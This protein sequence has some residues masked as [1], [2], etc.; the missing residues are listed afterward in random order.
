MLFLIFRAETTDHIHS[1]IIEASGSKNL[2]INSQLISFSMGTMIH[3]MQ[4]HQN[5]QHLVDLKNRN[6]NKI[7]LIRAIP[8]SRSRLSVPISVHFKHKI[9]HATDDAYSIC[10]LWDNS[11]HKW[12]T[13]DCTLLMSNRSHSTCACQKLATYALLVDPAYLPGHDKDAETD[14]YSATLIMIIVASS[15][16]V[17]LSILIIAIVIVYCRN[18]KVIIM[19]SLDSL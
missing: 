7:P 14:F 4:P 17:L 15:V 6:S 13:E 8:E 11:N 1:K 3:K 18:I 9:N 5:F 19:I 12:N 16:L 2:V 10:V